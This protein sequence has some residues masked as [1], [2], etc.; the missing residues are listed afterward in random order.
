[1]PS[2]SQPTFRH[3][4]SSNQHLRRR[5]RERTTSPGSFSRLPCNQPLRNRLVSLPGYSDHL[6]HRLRRCRQ[7][8]PRPLH[9]RQPPRR[10]LSD[11]LGNLPVCSNRRWHRRSLAHHRPR[12]PHARRSLRENSRE[13]SN[14]RLLRLSLLYLHRRQGNSRDCFNRRLLPPSLRR[15]PKHRRLR[16]RRSLAPPLRLR[17]RVRSPRCSG[18]LP[19]RR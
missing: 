2:L 19:A 14:H 7:P 10:S 4:R 17:S 12:Q 1:M 11:Q 18:H 9:K 8:I 3:C 13:R 15:L 6:R 16:P 5:R